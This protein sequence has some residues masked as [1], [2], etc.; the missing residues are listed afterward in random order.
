MSLT[1]IPASPPPTSALRALA[2][3]PSRRPFGARGIAI[4]AAEPDER[5]RLSATVGRAPGLRVVACHPSAV[6]LAAST[7]QH[8]ELAAGDLVLYDMAQPIEPSALRRAVA[9]LRARLPSM[10]VVGL[11]SPDD[12]H[13][14]YQAVLAG[15]DGCIFRPARLDELTQRLEEIARGAAPLCPGVAEQLMAMLRD[16]QQASKL[17]PTGVD[18]GQLTRREREVV[19]LLARGLA[20]KEVATVLS[21]GLDTVR[22]HV[23]R[24]YKKLGIHTAAEAAA[25]AVRNGMAE[26]G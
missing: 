8:D 14:V 23:R 11:V 20:Y 21:I 5:A 3:S 18:P 4:I 26:D 12:P 17:A 25:W 16:A 1:C 10:R 2:S 22:S 24:L 6:A 19:R 7:T 9:M 15:L 13:R